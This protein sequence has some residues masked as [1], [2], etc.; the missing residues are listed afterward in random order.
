MRWAPFELIGAAALLVP[1]TAFYAASALSLIMMG[2]MGTLLMH[3]GSMS[4]RTPL[5]HLVILAG[6]ALARRRATS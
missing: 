3:Q 6:I 5:V 2:A 1:G 4:W